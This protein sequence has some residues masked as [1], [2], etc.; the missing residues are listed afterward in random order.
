MM[1]SK[2]F[3]VI[4]QSLFIKKDMAK[5]KNS[6]TYK[7]KPASTLSEAL[8]LKNI[9]H[10]DR[11]NFILGVALFIIAGF[12]LWSFVSFLASG[13]A[14]M[15]IIETPRDGEILNQNH[16]FVNACG[17]VGAYTSWFFI[18]RCFGFAAFIIPVYIFLVFLRLVG[19]YKVKLLKWFMCLAIIMIWCS[20]A[21]AK[22]LAPLFDNAV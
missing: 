17:S 5:K 4:L 9:F 8:D 11:L 7:E 18:K 12:M 2:K 1:K 10:N 19:A 15:S 20:V 14:D 21:F 3:F 16:E 6:K 22:F 13:T